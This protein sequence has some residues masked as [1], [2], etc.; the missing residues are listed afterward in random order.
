MDIGNRLKEVTY[1][2]FEYLKGKTW[3]TEEIF[4]L[5]IAEKFPK[6][7]RHKTTDLV[8]LEHT[9]GDRC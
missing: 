6:T 8:S 7:N 5:K 9:E 1:T 3:R 2:Q 4:E